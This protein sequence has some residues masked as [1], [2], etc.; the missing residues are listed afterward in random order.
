MNWIRVDE[1]YQ[2]V[3]GF[4][5]PTIVLLRLM[6]W[7]PLEYASVAIILLLLSGWVVSIQTGKML[8]QKIQDM[9]TLNKNNLQSE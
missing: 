7:I 3:C 6:H 4:G 9:E 8:K 2:K 1:S 5:V